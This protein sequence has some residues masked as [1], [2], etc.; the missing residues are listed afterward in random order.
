VSQGGGGGGIRG[1]RVLNV[2]LST[3]A[4]EAVGEPNG[5][6]VRGGK[7]TVGTEARSKRGVHHRLLKV[8]KERGPFSLLGEKSSTKN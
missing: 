7:K 4:G 3:L 2:L 8:E 5:G 1:D 6:K